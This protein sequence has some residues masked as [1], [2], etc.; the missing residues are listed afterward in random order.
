ML[1]IIITTT[2]P[3]GPGAGA[4]EIKVNDVAV[5]LFN[6]VEEGHLDSA[7]AGLAFQIQLIE[8]L[9]ELTE[10]VR[11]MAEKWELSMQSDEVK[12][13]LDDA[14]GFQSRILEEAL[15]ISNPLLSS[16]STQVFPLLSWAS[17]VLF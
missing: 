8:V 1:I 13:H 7:C 17:S 3:I 16:K 2:E 15:E 9:N 12:I 6:Q 11:M 14:A 5:G 4:G 10:Q